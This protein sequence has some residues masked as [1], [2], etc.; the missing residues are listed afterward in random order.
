MR[1]FLY[2]GGFEGLYDVGGRY[3][4]TAIG[5]PAS[6]EIHLRSVRPDLPAPA[7]G[8]E[9]GPML[10]ARLS[11]ALQSVKGSIFSASRTRVLLR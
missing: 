7:E 9:N 3:T 4:R 11:V 5:D 1:H 6:G 8:A 2:Q 10:V